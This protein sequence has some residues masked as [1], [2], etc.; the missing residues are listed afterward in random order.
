[1][2]NTLATV[3]GSFV[4]IYYKLLEKACNISFTKST[5][6]KS[7]ILLKDEEKQEGRNVIIKRF[8]FH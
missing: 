2:G 4:G 7:E 8:T 1:M 6:N 5:S 3:L